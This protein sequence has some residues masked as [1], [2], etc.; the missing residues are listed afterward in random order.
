MPIRSKRTMSLTIFGTILFL[1]ASITAVSLQ[2]EPVEASSGPI[3]IEAPA[4][5][6]SAIASLLPA[7]AGA[8]GI[9]LVDPTSGVWHLRTRAGDPAMF[10]FGNPGDY[11]MIGDWNCSRDLAGDKRLAA[12]G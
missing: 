5:L 8:D 3:R 7:P 6:S 1:V 12:A 2:P 10:Y 4:E 11:P 9:G